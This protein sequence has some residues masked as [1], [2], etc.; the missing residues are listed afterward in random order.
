MLDIYPIHR[1]EYDTTTPEETARGA[2][3]NEGAAGRIIVAE[4][5]GRVHYLGEH[6]EPGAGIFLSS[7]INRY[8][9]VAASWRKDSSLR[10]YAADSG[11][12]KR[13]T[14]VNLKYKREDRWANYIKVAV[15]MFAEMGYEIHGLNFTVSGDIPQ[16]IALASSQAMEVASALALRRLLRANISDKELVYALASANK[17]FFEKD[18]PAENDTSLVDYNIIMFSKSNSFLVFDELTNETRKVK[19]PFGKHKIILTDSRVPWAGVDD[20]I[21]QRNADIKKGIEILSAQ[22]EGAHLRDY[23]KTDLQETLRSLP[24]GIRRR[25]SHVVREIERVEAAEKDLAAADLADFSR[26]VFHSHE[27]LRDLYEVSC[28]EIDWLVKRAQETEGVIASRITGK[29]FGGCT[30]SI[31]TPGGAVDYKARFE[32]YERIFGFH[33]ISHDIKQGTGA[34]IISNSNK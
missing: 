21:R 6:G 10:F 2:A 19:S 5:P 16:H 24:E 1:R 25:C 31:T 17:A 12:R 27:D 32:D 7:A 22:K 18:V 30:Y 11:E 14:L 28:P 4:A 15:Y 29:G 20:D 13:A 8:L 26:T 34:R 33:P 23:V 3:K 9:R